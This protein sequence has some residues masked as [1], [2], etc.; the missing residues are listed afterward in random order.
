MSSPCKLPQC[1]IRVGSNRCVAFGPGDDELPESAWHSKGP[2]E[3]ERVAEWLAQ[4]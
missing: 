4:T 3:G 1:G 2:G